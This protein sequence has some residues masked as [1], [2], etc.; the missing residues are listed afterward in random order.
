M[1]GGGRDIVLSD[2][3]ALPYVDAAIQEVMRIVSLVPA[4]FE[5]RAKHDGAE[6]AGY[7]I[8]RK[9]HVVG[10]LYAAMHDPKVF[11]EPHVFRSER[12]LDLNGQ[13][14]AQEAFIPFGMGR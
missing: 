3:K 14:K 7:K 12:F 2:R 9:C 4:T 1:T 11:P 10:N 6:I 8:P 5:H 13:M